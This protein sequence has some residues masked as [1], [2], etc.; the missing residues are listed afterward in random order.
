MDENLSSF[1]LSFWKKATINGKEASKERNE[2]EE[3]KRVPE[4][5]K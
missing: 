4:V 1:L 2:G 3:E 5:R